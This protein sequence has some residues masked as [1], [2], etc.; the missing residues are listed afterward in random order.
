M[1]GFQFECGG[2]H[3]LGHNAA[4]RSALP[5]RFPGV[6]AALNVGVEAVLVGG[7]RSLDMAGPVVGQHLGLSLL[8]RVERLLGDLAGRDLGIL[9][10]AGHVGVDKAGVHSDDQG[11]LADL[12]RDMTRPRMPDGE[13]E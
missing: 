5:G 1:T 9:N 6:P 7:D 13:D 10:G 4:T 2:V 3:A 12:V 11:A 8:D